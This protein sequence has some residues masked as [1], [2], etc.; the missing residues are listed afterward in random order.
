M[1][2]YVMPY[3]NTRM[4][5]L[6]QAIGVCPKCVRNVLDILASCTGG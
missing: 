4:G 5:G 1:N 6:T 3:R 2:E